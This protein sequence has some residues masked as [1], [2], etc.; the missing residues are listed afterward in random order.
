MTLEE[1]APMTTATNAEMGKF[2]I[3]IYGVRT[4]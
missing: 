3:R 1:F 4:F 2:Q